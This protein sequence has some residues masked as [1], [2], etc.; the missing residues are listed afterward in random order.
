MAFSCKGR[1]FCPSCGAAES[2]AAAMGAVAAVRVAVSL[3]MKPNVMTQVL[4][5]VYRAISG[6]I[7]RKAGTSRR[8]AET[9]AV[10]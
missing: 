7:R 6:H 8:Q 10:R 9:G 4:E 1:G 3:V 2:A 5:I